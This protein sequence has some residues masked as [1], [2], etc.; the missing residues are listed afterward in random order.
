MIESKWT[1][2]MYFKH[3]FLST[4]TR[5][6][7]YLNFC[8]FL[9]LKLHAVMPIFIFCLMTPLKI[10]P[11]TIFLSFYAFLRRKRL[12]YCWNVMVSRKNLKIWWWCNLRILNLTLVR[13]NNPLIFF[14]SLSIFK[15][16]AK[17]V[18]LAYRP[19]AIGFVNNFTMNCFMRNFWRDC[20]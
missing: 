14:Y 3:L 19:S 8:S 16:C 1:F 20:L 13:M 4:F 9:I 18:I 5:L 12:T 11:T 17:V 15:Y 2:Q 10:S 7:H 6:N